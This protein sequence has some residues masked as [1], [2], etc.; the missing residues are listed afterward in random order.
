MQKKNGY[1]YTWF[2][3]LYTWNE[4][5]IASQLY[6]DKIKTQDVGVGKKKKEKRNQDQQSGNSGYKM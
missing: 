2:T 3:L 4:Y 5:N 1:M 6:S